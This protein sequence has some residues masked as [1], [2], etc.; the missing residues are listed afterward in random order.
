MFFTRPK[1]HWPGGFA[2]KMLLNP[3]C[4]ASRTL[5]CAGF[6]VLVVKCAKRV[7]QIVKM[8]WLAWIL[9]CAKSFEKVVKMRRPGRVA[10]KML[11][12]PTRG[13]SRTLKC[14]GIPC[15]GR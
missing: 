6:L 13:A 12:K 7:E 8:H 5:K 2:S 11:L 1:M 9:K 4:G 10:F 15:C 14:A 3:I